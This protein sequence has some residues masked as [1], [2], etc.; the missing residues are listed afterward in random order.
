MSDTLKRRGEKVGDEISLAFWQW[1]VKEKAG[2]K[3]GDEIS[4][5]F[6]PLFFHHF[7]TRLQINWRGIHKNV[8]LLAIK[9]IQ[10]AT[11]QS[12]RQT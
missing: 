10:A 5:V 8:K 4:L 12:I 7:Q 6:W 2:E 11:E 9:R 3:V 1:R